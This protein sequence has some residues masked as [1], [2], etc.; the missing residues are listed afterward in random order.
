MSLT[1]LTFGQKF[2]DLFHACFRELQSKGLIDLNKVQRLNEE[3]VEAGYY[4]QFSIPSFLSA[5]YLYADVFNK[6]EA[7]YFEV[8]FYH[9]G[10]VELQWEF[11]RRDEEG[12]L[13]DRY[14]LEAI[15]TPDGEVFHVFID[16]NLRPEVDGYYL[17]SN[18]ADE[19]SNA[20][21]LTQ[22]LQYYSRNV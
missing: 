19:Q 21:H 9:G 10:N 17:S 4:K 15:F 6:V 14:E 13:V 12:D 2:S 18:Y 3:M 22:I 7:D 20:N 11:Y 8:V 16:E 1:D 5:L